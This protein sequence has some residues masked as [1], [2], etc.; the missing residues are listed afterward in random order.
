MEGV[1]RPEIDPGATGETSDG[2]RMR[3]ALHDSAVIHDH[4]SGSW[5]VGAVDI[6]E[7]TRPAGERIEEL[8]ALLESSSA[9]IVPDLSAPPTTPADMPAPNMTK[10]EYLTK[11]GRAIRYIEAGDI[12]QVNLTQ[13]FTTRTAVP[14]VELYLRL[15]RANPAAFAAFLPWDDRTVLSSSPE[16]FLD[17]WPDRRVITRPIKGT[18]PRTGNP[19]IDAAREAELLASHKDRAELNM[20]ID[21]QR[22][23]LG[24]VCEFGSIRVLAD[25]DIEWHPTVVHLVAS[26][27]GR[28]RAGVS[29][30]DLLRATFPGGSITGCPKIRAMQII[31]ELEPTPRDVYCGSI[32]YIGLDGRLSMNIA[33]RTMLLEG[34]LL[35]MYAGGAITG[36]SD[37]ES[38]YRE[39]LAK[40]EG[41]FRALG[42]SSAE[43]ATSADRVTPRHSL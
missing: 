35:H 8:T 17:L 24:R 19:K 10:R 25:H 43:L 37:P 13:R 33:I 5:H 39:S 41:M 3:F 20:I 40:A 21:L 32:G 26:I 22:N 29:P 30:V 27:E 18:R 38:E 28:L 14:P 42:R 9:A 6:E 7:S 15:R 31:N 1:R 16:L 36:D 11:V 23:D 12:Y 4:A 34:D 2:P